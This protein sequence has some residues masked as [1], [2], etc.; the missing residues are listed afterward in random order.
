MRKDSAGG[1][2]AGRT[3]S[4]TAGLLAWTCL[5]AVTGCTLCSSVPLPALPSRR[6]ARA[7]A[8]A[9]A[10]RAASLASAPRPGPLDT[11]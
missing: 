2:A 1:G 10:R 9:P 8:R 5:G 11:F 3:R 6:R 7:C 4:C